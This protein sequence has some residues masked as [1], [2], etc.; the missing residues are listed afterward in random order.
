MTLANDWVFLFLGQ[1]ILGNMVFNVPDRVDPF[2]DGGSRLL[3]LVE[4]CK[5][6]VILLKNPFVAD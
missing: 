4:R 5:A 2:R 1:P 3:I 6:R